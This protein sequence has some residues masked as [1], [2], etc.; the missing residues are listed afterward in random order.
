MSEDPKK[1]F[2]DLGAMLAP[3]FDEQRAVWEREGP[4]AE[5][6]AAALGIA[7]DDRGGNCTVQA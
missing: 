3:V 6:R 2:D 4:A 7:F 5:A 1:F